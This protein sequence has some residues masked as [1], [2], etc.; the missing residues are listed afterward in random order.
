MENSL[1]RVRYPD[2]TILIN[3][4][5]AYRVSESGYVMA[6]YPLTGSILHKNFQISISRIQE[7]FL[8]INYALFE[9][10]ASVCI[11]NR[12]GNIILDHCARLIVTS[13]D[14]SIKLI[15]IPIL[16]TRIGNN[17][18]SARVSSPS[19]ESLIGSQIELVSLM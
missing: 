19:I 10:C 2:R 5:M 9:T 18:K 1:I 4:K 15:Y 11:I 8:L 14:L 16:S 13:E 3:F 6:P 7:N 17:T 12:N